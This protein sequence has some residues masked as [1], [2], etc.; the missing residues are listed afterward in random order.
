MEQ[1]H[2][3]KGLQAAHLLAD[4]GGGHAQL[5]GSAG[6]AAQARGGLESPE[7]IEGRKGFLHL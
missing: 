1:G 6:E 2:I 7:G 4:G 3:Q 5:D